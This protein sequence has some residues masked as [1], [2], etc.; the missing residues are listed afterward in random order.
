[1]ASSGFEDSIELP[2]RPWKPGPPT[3][4]TYPYPEPVSD[5][6]IEVRQ[7]RCVCLENP[8]IRVRILPDW[9]PRIWSLWDRRTET[10]ILWQPEHLELSRDPGPAGVWQVRGGLEVQPLGPS[11]PSCPATAT[12]TATTLGEG[13]AAEC[14]VSSLI[15]GAGL[16]V[17]SRIQVPADSAEV[18][19]EVRVQQR[20]I[21]LRE[22]V[23]YVGQLRAFVGGGAAHL[24]PVSET[25]V[26]YDAVRDVGLA[27]LGADYRFEH[28]HYD[29]AALEIARFTHPVPLLPRQLDEWRVK[30]TPLSGL[31]GVTAVADEAA[32]HLESSRLSILSRRS[33]ES[34]KVL[35]G[36]H[37]GETFEVTSPLEAG[38]PRSIALDRLPGAPMAVL[39]RSTDG[40]E[41]LQWDQAASLMPLDRYMPPE[42]RQTAFRFGKVMRQAMEWPARI[43]RE[44]TSQLQ[45]GED[46]RRRLNSAEFFPSF[47]AVSH[48]ALAQ[49]YLREGDPLAAA[50]EVEH[51]LNYNAE[52]HLAWWMKALT[53]RL[54]GADP[55]VAVELPNAHFL[56]PDEPILRVEAFLSQ[57]RRDAE[58]ERAILEPLHELP[59]WVCEALCL[60]V[61]AGVYADAAR[62]AEAALA[63]RPLP[64]VH[65]LLAYC[66]LTHSKMNAEAATH[67]SLASQLPN[68]P[69]YAWRAAEIRAMET[70]QEAGLGDER[71]RERLLLAYEAG[72][73]SDGRHGQVNLG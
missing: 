70:L 47:R 67:V 17:Q 2:V 59:E 35:V 64:S 6:G 66:L 14:L 39:V 32:I 31:G 36:V 51:A 18:V 68:Q 44:G 43:Y 48:L 41:L 60:L 3:A 9:G 15:A 69:P 8:Y 61:E 42:H 40:T 5:S 16:W 57:P 22:D 63:V 1:M 50:S 34:A 30:L 21:E 65:Y 26:W 4:A 46:P 72:F 37:T 13:A 19:I 12:C 62:F 55:D 33:H 58:R 29:S 73:G 24:D 38:T 23:P 45:A 20:Q 28:F 11:A 27:V 52:D 7:V 56:A 53:T 49:Y 54:V 71:L 25:L 10:E